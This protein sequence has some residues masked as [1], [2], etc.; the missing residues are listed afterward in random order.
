M[1]ID[2]HLYHVWLCYVCP[3]F[4]RILFKM[5]RSKSYQITQDT[6]QHNIRLGALP[7]KTKN[8]CKLI[9]LFLKR[10][11]TVYR[12]L[13][14]PICAHPSFEADVLQEFTQL[15]T[16][17]T[18]PSQNLFLWTTKKTNHVRLQFKWRTQQLQHH[19]PIILRLWGTFDIS[20]LPNL[21]MTISRLTANCKTIFLGYLVKS[22]R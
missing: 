4:I 5:N 15:P 14:L 13:I 21:S 16:S 12:W 11:P 20:I 1:C 17:S 3:T 8:T 18:S 9:Y 19:T 10:M 2:N 7:K 22:Q 6:Y